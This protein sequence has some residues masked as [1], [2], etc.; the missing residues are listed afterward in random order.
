LG[1][2]FVLGLNVKF[3]IKIIATNHHPQWLLS[4]YGYLNIS[5]SG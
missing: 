1:V 4:D 3:K 2:G 5:T